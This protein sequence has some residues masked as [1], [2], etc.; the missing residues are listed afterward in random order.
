MKNLMLFAALAAS[1]CAPTTA[2]TPKIGSAMPASIVDPYLKIQSA[3]A[4]DSVQGVH[5]AAGE[6]V[7]AATALGAPAMR[8]DTAAISLAAASEAAQPDLADI[9]TKFGTLSEALVTYVTGEKLALPAGVKTAWCPMVE[10]PWMQKGET[11]SNPY[12]GK[13]MSTCGDFR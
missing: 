9:R 2:G 6:L 7:T 10:K 4:D 13:E 3:L 12:Y 11:I 8:I 5:M 1:A